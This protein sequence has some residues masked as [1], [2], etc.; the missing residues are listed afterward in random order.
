MK[1][2]LLFK[3]L[4]SG[5]GATAAFAVSAHAQNLLV[6]GDFESASLFTANPI[7]PTSVLPGGTSGVNQGWATYG[8][9]GQSDMSSSPDS[10]QSGSYA[11]IE[12]QGAGGSWSVPGAYQIV[13]P[14]GGIVA[15]DTYTLSGYYLSDA[16]PSGSVLAGDEF[17]FRGDWNGTTFPTIGT[18]VNNYWTALT[19]N[20]V[21]IPF[22][23][24]EVA[25]A[26]A[27]GIIAYLQMGGGGGGPATDL[28]YDN[29]SVIDV[30]AV[31][32]PTTLALAG[33]GGMSL[34]SLIR[35][36]NS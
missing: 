33:L 29:V 36:R 14:V 35:R 1:R 34:L 9:T 26:G 27:T 23:L 3:I 22:S 20:D 7:S 10:P 28:Y 32:E 16:N 24:S 30:S 5:V 6:N 8:G 15:G 18:D 2:K 4:A 13:Q 25:P 11:L 19:A 12:P 31:P 17:G 21:W